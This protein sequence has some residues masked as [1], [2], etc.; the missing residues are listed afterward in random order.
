[1]SWRVLN[2]IYNAEGIKRRLVALTG[3]E[4]ASCQFSSVQLGLSSCVFGLVQFAA[5]AFRAVRMAD[6]LPRCCPAPRIRLLAG[7]SKTRRS[8]RQG[9]S[10]ARNPTSSEAPGSRPRPAAENALAIADISRYRPRD[11]GD[12]CAHRPLYDNPTYRPLHGTLPDK[13]ATAGI[14]AKHILV[15]HGWR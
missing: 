15:T 13:G 5:R 14:L 8:A 2:E 11:G 3:V 4:P 1:M 10:G 6:V 12:A 7:Q 9:V